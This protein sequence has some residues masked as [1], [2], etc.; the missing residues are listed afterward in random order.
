MGGFK[1]CPHGARADY[2]GMAKESGWWSHR[3]L[4]VF[5]LAAWPSCSDCR[6]WEA[7]WARRCKTATSVLGMQHSTNLRLERMAAFH[8]AG[9]LDT[10]DL[11]GGGSWKSQLCVE[12][13]ME[14]IGPEIQEP[15][16]RTGS[17]MME[18]KMLLGINILW[19]ECHTTKT[20]EFTWE[21]GILKVPEST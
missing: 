17:S 3:K 6:I 8:Q 18:A 14:S 19:R 1:E 7:V 11:G 15:L 10:P 21:E 16:P 20:R 4:S 5:S 12:F 2:W 9:K 13:W